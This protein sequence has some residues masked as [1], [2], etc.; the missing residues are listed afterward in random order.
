M[1]LPILYSESI[2]SFTPNQQVLPLVGFRSGAIDYIGIQ[3]SS[4]QSS[5]ASWDSG[6][7][8]YGN[9]VKRDPMRG[10]GKWFGP[11]AVW[12]YANNLA[13]SGKMEALDHDEIARI[14]SGAAIT[15]S[16][17]KANA[18]FIDATGQWRVILQSADGSI[19]HTGLQDALTYSVP[20]LLASAVLWVRLENAIR[21]WQMPPDYL[22]VTGYSAIPNQ[23]QYTENSE[24]YVWDYIYDVGRRPTDTSNPLYAAYN[25]AQQAGLLKHRSLWTQYISD[26]TPQGGPWSA[27]RIAIDTDDF[28]VESTFIPAPGSCMINAAGDNIFIHA[29]ASSVAVY[30]SLGNGQRIAGTIATTKGVAV[31]YWD[32]NSGAPDLLA[33]NYNIGTMV[34][35]SSLYPTPDSIIQLDD[36]T[37][38][39]LTWSYLFRYD[40]TQTGIEN[41]LIGVPLN[42]GGH[43]GGRCLT[44]ADGVDPSYFTENFN[45]GA[46]TMGATGGTG[47]IQMYNT[48]RTLDG[49]GVGK[50]GIGTVFH[51]NNCADVCWGNLWGWVQDGVW[52][53]SDGNAL[54]PSQYLAFIANEMWE[55]SSIAPFDT[56]YQMWQ[57]VARVANKNGQRLVV[58]GKERN[59]EGAVW[60]IHD[61]RT[62]TFAMSIPAAVTSL[63]AAL[64][65][66][67]S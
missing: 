60:G 41:R 31:A 53:D 1:S 27:L 50:T 51:G 56:Q 59:G 54:N 35:E 42:T 3:P 67:V 43:P 8:E 25:Q 58:S 4:W 26:G 18:G 40:G 14:P 33:V 2:Y 38:L 55:A 10:Y 47:F 15:A 28:A 65:A 21:A 12:I 46:S 29:T 20:S 11:G 61:G 48:L 66:S 64:N 16:W 24:D 30:N 32:W 37:E 36:D 5:E 23:Y 44:S 39:L 7:P 52:S 22:E 9:N 45:S 34:C 13:I 19:L 49:S 62:F 63:V 6:C 57:R 17:E